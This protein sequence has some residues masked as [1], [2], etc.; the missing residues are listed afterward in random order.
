MV[1]RDDNSL[2]TLSISNWNLLLSLRCSN[3]SQVSVIHATSPLTFNALRK[4]PNLWTKFNY[5]DLDYNLMDFCV[6]RENLLLRVFCCNEKIN[7]IVIKISSFVRQTHTRHVFLP[8][9]STEC[10]C[11]FP[12]ED[13]SVMRKDLSRVKYLQINTTQG[14]EKTMMF[15]NILEDR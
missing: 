11:L 10:Q 7:G 3:R 4:L 2:Q 5:D 12:F 8:A 13:E 6:F 1:R 9:R 15:L 14:L